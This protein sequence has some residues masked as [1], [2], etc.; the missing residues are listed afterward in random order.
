MRFSIPYPFLRSILTELS[1]RAYHV[2][3]GRIGVN[4]L[5]SGDTELMAGS[6]RFLHEGALRRGQD[7]QS[8]RFELGFVPFTLNRPEVWRAVALAARI[9]GDLPS[10]PTCSVML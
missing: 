2:A 8:P 9:E 6:V 3:V 7:D 10:L 4:H 5:P 1:R